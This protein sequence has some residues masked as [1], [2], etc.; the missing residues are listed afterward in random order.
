GKYCN[1]LPEAVYPTPFY[2]TIMATIFFLILWSLRKKLKPYGAVF[3]LYLIFNGLE[4]FLIEQIR[5][6]NK[7]DFLGLQPTQAEIIAVGLVLT[8]IGLWIY[9]QKKYGAKPVNL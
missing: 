2:E 1:V 5:V 3:A 8:G 9:L 4:R 7:M 6:N